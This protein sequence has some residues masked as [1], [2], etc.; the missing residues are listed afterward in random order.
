MKS[1]SNKT[2]TIL[3]HILPILVEAV[4]DNRN[5][6]VCNAVRMANIILRKLE[7]KKEK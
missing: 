2:I 3:C 4:K 7:K 1:V 6:Q 5:I